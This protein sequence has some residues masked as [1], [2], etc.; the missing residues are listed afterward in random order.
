M[1][2]NR[3]SNPFPIEV[4]PDRQ[5]QIPNCF[6]NSGWENRVSMDQTH[7]FESTLGSIVSSPVTTTMGGGEGEDGIMKGLIGRLGG[8]CNPGEISSYAASLNSPP[9]LGLSMVD[10]QI[11]GD[12]LMGR[13]QFPPLSAQ[14]FVS[15]STDPDFAERAARFSC[16]GKRED[17]NGGFN[18]RLGSS[19]GSQTVAGETGDSREG[20]SLT[21]QTPKRETSNNGNGRKRK[22]S[23]RGKSKDTVSGENN[24]QSP[25]KIK[26]DEAKG[27]DEHADEVARAEER[28]SNSK[29]SEPP[30]DYIHVR[31]RR[32]QAT[33]SHSLAERVRREKISQRMK[34]L[35]DLVPG[36]SKVTG[37]AIMLDEI[38]NY[39]QS[40]QRQ[41][42]FLSLKLATLN[43]RLEFEVEALLPNDN[44]QSSEPFAHPDFPVNSS[45]T[46][47]FLTDFQPPH[48]S[49]MAAMSEVQFPGDPTNTALNGFLDPPASQVPASWDDDL[50]NEVQNLQM[51]ISHS[52]QPLSFHG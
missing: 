39:V 25:K 43:P 36:C 38:I 42:E 50:Q 2:G 33:D 22:P 13:I 21:E 48:P 31:A 15:F 34:V 52:N 49:M 17:F 1:E 41:V 11:G 30:K 12:L 19:Y 8:I 26:L 16:F 27:S 24:Q 5:G 23:Q 37:K 3:C 32:G 18:G 35:Q 20:S 40:L 6:V 28:P 14:S 45:F 44:V 47:P 29:P 10:H 46:P 9:K 4:N 7:P 51:G